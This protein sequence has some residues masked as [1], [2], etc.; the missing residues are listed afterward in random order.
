MIDNNGRV[1]LETAMVRQGLESRMD[2]LLLAN[3]KRTW[4]RWRNTGR[5]VALITRRAE[6]GSEIFAIEIVEWREK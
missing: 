3:M 1:V 6:F 4:K 5:K 2:R